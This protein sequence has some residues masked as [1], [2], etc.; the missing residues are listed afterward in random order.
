MEN[1]KEQIVEHCLLL[2]HLKYN[3]TLKIVKIRYNGL[4]NNHPY[5]DEIENLMTN[6][7]NEMIVNIDYSLELLINFYKSMIKYDK[8]LIKSQRR[9]SV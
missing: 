3:N 2:N 9:N 5:K 4:I 1:I 7:K 8:L 6:D